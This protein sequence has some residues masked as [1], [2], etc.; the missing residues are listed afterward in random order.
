M[1]MFVLLSPSYGLPHAQKIRSTTRQ[2]I[3]RVDTIFGFLLPL[4]QTENNVLL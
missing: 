3:K 4:G 1:F 2:K